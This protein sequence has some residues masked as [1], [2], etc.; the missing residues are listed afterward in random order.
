MRGMCSGTRPRAAWVGSSRCSSPRTRRGAQVS[1]GY[2]FNFESCDITEMCGR[3][4]RLKPPPAPLAAIARWQEEHGWPFELYTEASLD[5][6]GD[7]G[8]TQGLVD[9]GLT[10]VFVGLESPDRKR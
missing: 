5:L 7:D 3:A 8:L 9:A 10:S 4:P 1:R 6:A 2:P